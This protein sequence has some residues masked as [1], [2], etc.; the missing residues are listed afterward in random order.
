M[1]FNASRMFGFRSGMDSVLH[2]RAPVEKVGYS[3]WPYN[4]WRGP[5]LYNYH[6]LSATSSLD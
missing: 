1:I 2:I 6:Q 3:I 5:T 4:L